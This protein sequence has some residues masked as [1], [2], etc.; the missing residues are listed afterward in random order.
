[1]DIKKQLESKFDNNELP[2]Y[3]AQY[4]A[5]KKEIELS[6]E[7]FW[8]QNKTEIVKVRRK[9][10]HP[11]FTQAPRNTQ[12][13][14]EERNLTQE[15]IQ[16]LVKLCETDMY[17]YAIR[18]FPHYLKKPSSKLHTFVYNLL[19][20]EINKTER[21]DG[22]K[23]AIAAPRGNA[24]SSIISAIFPL[25]CI[26]YNKKKFIVLVSDTAGQ[27]EDF[28]SDI[29][30]EILTNEKLQRDFPHIKGEGPTWRTN[31]IITNNSIKLIALGSG[32][33]IRGR[34][35]GVNRPDL[36]I[37]DDVENSDDYRSKAKREFLRYKWFEKDVLFAGGEKGTITDIIFI[38]TILGNKSLLCSLTNPE[39]YPDW[40][41]KVFKAVEKFSDSILWDKWAELYRN[42]FDN[43]R[44]VTAR[45]FFEENEEEMLRGTEVLWP[46]GDPYYDNMIEMYFRP[47]AFQTEKQNSGLDPTKILVTIDQ[48]HF[49]DFTDTQISTLL[50]TKRRTIRYGALD[51]SLGKK[52]DVGDFSCI[53]T[54]AK[55]RKTGYLFVEDIMLSRISVDAQIDLILKY[56]NK[57]KYTLFGIET[58]AFQHVISEN[59]RKQSRKQSIYVPIKDLPNYSDKK[60]RVEGIVPLL[61]DGTIVFD[62]YKYK[63]N[64]QYRNGVDQLCLFTGVDDAND[65]MPDALEMAVR[66]A[67]QKRFKR[68]TRQAKV[69]NRK[70]KNIK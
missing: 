16:I 14:E 44:I 2:D 48:L 67:R 64:Q 32:N 11:V 33:Q 26:C 58:N 4:F 8:K 10:N 56:Q 47:A 23:W 22:F 5:N 41:R 3:L 20:G 7:E 60:L 18:Y 55:D 30:R 21:L 50:K 45:K 40:K 39:D 24:K 69:Q 54:L 17:L 70:Q 63:V 38:G 36:I 29:K 12:R 13:V 43:N 6:D 1:M 42:R 35:F 37:G 51:P 46:E 66:I 68:R 15:E 62:S 53:V 27:A 34:R 19:S 61:V 25:W 59:L 52:S 9:T 57:F 49:A 31:E 65:D 28:L